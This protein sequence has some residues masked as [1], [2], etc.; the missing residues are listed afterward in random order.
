MDSDSSDGSIQSDVYAFGMTALEVRILST[1]K[2]LGL[3]VFFFPQLLTG[4]PPFSHR[5]HAAQAIRDVVT[6]IRPPKECCTEVDENVWKLLE[7]C[8]MHDS[9]KRPSAQDVLCQITS[10]VKNTS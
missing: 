7:A 5:R 4:R 8:W 10:I 1:T 2:S 6:G 9:A 3:I